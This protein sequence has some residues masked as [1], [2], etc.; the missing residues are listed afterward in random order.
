MLA[1]DITGHA[2]LVTRL[3]SSALTSATVTRAAVHPHWRETYVGTTVSDTVLEGV[4]DLLYRDD[5][6]LVVVDYKTDAIPAG[7]L[8]ARRDYY[9]PQLIAYAD[10]LS[11]AGPQVASAALLFLTPAGEAVSADV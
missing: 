8:A 7:A 1:E 10:M 2:E 9:R 4:V 6:G 3:A 5:D 11:T